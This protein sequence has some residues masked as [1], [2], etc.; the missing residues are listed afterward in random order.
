MVPEKSLLFSVLPLPS[1]VFAELPVALARLKELADRKG[2]AVMPPLMLPVLSTEL[3]LDWLAATFSTICT[4]SVSPTRRARWS[5]NSGR[6]CAAWKIA[7]L[8]TGGAR[9]A[10]VHVRGCGRGRHLERGLAVVGD[11]LLP[12]SPQP[13]SA[14]Q[15]RHGQ[16]GRAGGEQ[17]GGAIRL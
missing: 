6:Y 17:H 9:W 8:L 3:V 1:K 2:S 12:G 14:A 7:P 13:H 10:A 11:A 4:V 5:S 16:N 15:Q